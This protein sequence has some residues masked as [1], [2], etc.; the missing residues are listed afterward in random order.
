MGIRLG[1]ECI[2]SVPLLRRPTCF[3]ELYNPDNGRKSIARPKPGQAV[4]PVGCN[5]SCE[6]EYRRAQSSVICQVELGQLV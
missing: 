5:S 1:V 6:L 2:D 3:A 4:D